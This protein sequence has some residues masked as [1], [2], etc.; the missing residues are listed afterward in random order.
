MFSVLGPSMRG[1]RR[2]KQSFVQNPRSNNNTPDESVSWMF[3]RH[4]SY[5]MSSSSTGYSHVDS[6]TSTISF[7]LDKR[8]RQN[9]LESQ[10]MENYV[11]NVATLLDRKSVV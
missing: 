7:E 9:I 8:Y 5:G 10:L 1:E 4:G 2:T 6:M 3:S 11:R